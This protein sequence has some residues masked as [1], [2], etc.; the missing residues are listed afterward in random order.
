VSTFGS[1][2]LD[3]PV[4][5]ERLTTGVLRLDTML[6]GGYYR[7]SSVLVSGAPGT[8]KTTLAARYLETMWTR[9]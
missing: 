8:A 7:G 9:A 4:S 2:T 5:D 3:Y 6:G 1:A